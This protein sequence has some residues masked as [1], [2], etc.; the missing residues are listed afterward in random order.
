M[1]GAPPLDK[2]HKCINLS[3]KT[4]DLCEMP[5]GQLSEVEYTFEESQGCD[6]FWPVEDLRGECLRD[7]PGHNHGFKPLTKRHRRKGGFWE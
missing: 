4:R 3:C 2:L 5:K 1:I 6:Y 7:N